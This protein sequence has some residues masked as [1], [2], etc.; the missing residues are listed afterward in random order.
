MLL[1]HTPSR[2]STV[3]SGF[4]MLSMRI[5]MLWPKGPSLAQSC[6]LMAAWKV[7]Q[8]SFPEEKPLGY[9]ESQFR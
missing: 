5:L 6:S 7:C 8:S 9:G 2:S 4:Q 3:R 1:S